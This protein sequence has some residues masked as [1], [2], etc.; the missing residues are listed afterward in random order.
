[1]FPQKFNKSVACDHLND[2]DVHAEYD[3]KRE[4]ERLES[5][6]VKYQVSLTF[7]LGSGSASVKLETDEIPLTF[8]VAMLGEVVP[9][10]FH[11]LTRVATRLLNEAMKDG[12]DDE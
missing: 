3:I 6:N 2:M 5:S 8:P 4:S 9:E 12:T 11:E 1:M 7:R 10:V